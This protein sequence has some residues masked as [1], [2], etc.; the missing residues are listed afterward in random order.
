[1]HDTA[2]AETLPALLSD[3]ARRYADRPAME[4]QNRVWNYAALDALVD[5]AARGLQK[6]GAAPGVRVGLCLP[7]T[8]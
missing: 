4:F 5:R 3:S 7:N 8:P 2:S 6:L 1:M